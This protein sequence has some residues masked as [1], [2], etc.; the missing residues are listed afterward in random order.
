MLIQGYPA[1]DAVSEFGRKSREQTTDLCYRFLEA[2][3]SR[4]GELLLDECHENGVF[5][6][7][8]KFNLVLRGRIQG[9]IVTDEDQALGFWMF[10]LFYLI[11][12][13]CDS[14]V[15]VTEDY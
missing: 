9:A 10:V 1:P 13:H 5:R 3:K 7:S 15:S 2:V 8:S 12:D 14:K 11:E 6:I 4:V